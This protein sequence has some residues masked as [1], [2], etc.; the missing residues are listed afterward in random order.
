MKN[1]I[2][3]IIFV[4]LIF[5]LGGKTVLNSAPYVIKDIAT[6]PYSEL[7][8][9]IDADVTK[10]FAQKYTWINANG[11][12]Q[13]L[14]GKRIV[15]NTEKDVYR[16]SNGMIV[17]ANDY[18]DSATIQNYADKVALLA[19]NANQDCEF[20]FVE[21]PYKEKSGDKITPDGVENYANINADNLLSA[22]QANGIKTLDIREEIDKA[23]LDHY[24]LFFNTDHHWKPSTAL[25]AAGVLNKHFKDELGWKYDP[26]YYDIKNYK[27]K[28]YKDWFLGA[29]GKRIGDWYSGVDDFD[30][31]TPKFDT[32]YS[33]TADSENGTI[34]REGDFNKV[35][36]KKK[37]LKNKNYFKASPYYA[38]IGG[39]YKITEIHNDSALNNKKVLLIS[40]SYKCTL[41]P[42]LSNAVSDLTTIDARYYKKMKLSDY[43]SSHKYDAIIIAYNPTVFEDR[44]FDF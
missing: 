8:S 12:F 6:A 3:A 43:V 39:D 24:S 1:K 41:I 44:A 28:T 26:Y 25:W 4:L 33:F 16:A 27:V 38:Y 20:L 22:I 10:N 15:E 14:I 42:Y 21:L 35:M 37:R 17:G 19:K 2:V 36:I 9:T 13:K 32:S 29:Q 31:I 18:L 5:V 11:L 40:D 7:S 34:N 30:L 23:G